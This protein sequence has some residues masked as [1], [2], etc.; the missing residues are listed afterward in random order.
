MMIYI[1]ILYTHII[2]IDIYIYIIYKYNRVGVLLP[3][4]QN[5][6]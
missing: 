3:G 1:Y 4:I 6:I 5:L 2:L